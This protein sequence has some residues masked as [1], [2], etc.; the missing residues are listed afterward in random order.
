MSLRTDIHIAFDQL[1][2]STLGLPERVLESA[3]VKPTGRTAPRRWIVAF[4][5]PAS[6][7]AVFLLVA[8]VAA[9]LVGGRVMQDWKAFQKSATAGGGPS[10][11]AQLQAR[12]MQLPLLKGNSTCPETPLNALPGGRF[13]SGLYGSGPSYIAG[14]ST[15]ST[16]WGTY[17][18]LAAV[19]TGEHNKLLLLRGRDLHTGQPVIFVDKWSAG[20]V[21]G[22]DSVSGKLTQQHTELLLDRRHP[23]QNTI[24][25]G[26]VTWGFTAGLANGASGCTAWQF[27]SIDNGSELIVTRSNPG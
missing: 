4:R 8:L 16:R 2:P 18:Y 11:L 23:P 19:T 22:M 14:G 24:Q 6:L 5:G 26:T 1:A 20:P 7:V 10:E 12:P 17:S 13:P 27:D 25:A 3:Q 21:L 15:L 9:L